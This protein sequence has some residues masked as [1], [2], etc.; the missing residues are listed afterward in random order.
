[1]KNIGRNPCICLDI[2]NKSRSA[3]AATYV[4]L[5]A[6]MQN[7]KGGFLHIFCKKEC[8]N[9]SLPLKAVLFGLVTL[10][11]LKCSLGVDGGHS[12]HVQETLSPA[13]FQTLKKKLWAGT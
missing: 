13:V 1:M 8:W 3:G 11:P 10:L 12:A 9:L 7:I 2:A 5:V 4:L 6:F